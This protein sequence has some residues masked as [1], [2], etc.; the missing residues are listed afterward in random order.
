MNNINNALIY[1]FA[2]TRFEAIGVRSPAGA[3]D[4]S[5]NLCFQTSSEAHQAS[6]PIGTGGTFPG[7]KS[8]R[9]V[10]LATHPI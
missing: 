4:F 6:Y 8:G 10:T 1:Y 2:N 5:S 3:K 9:G 7:A